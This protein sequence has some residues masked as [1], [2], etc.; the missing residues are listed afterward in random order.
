I[1]FISAKSF[2]E[3]SEIANFPNN[4]S[5]IIYNPISNQFKYNN[6]RI[7]KTSPV[8]LHIGTKDN[9]NLERSIISKCIIVA[10]RISTKL[11]YFGISR[12][13]NNV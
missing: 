9:K 5:H 11:E 3:V 1:T 12:R 7:H 13:Y 8:V 6:K 2:Q 4:K 10:C